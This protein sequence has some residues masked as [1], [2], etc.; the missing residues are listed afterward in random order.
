MVLVLCM[1]FVLSLASGSAVGVDE[2]EAILQKKETK[3]I[4]LLGRDSSSGLADAIII[5][6][7]NADREKLTLLQIPRDTYIF[8]SEEKYKKINGASAILGSDSALCNRLSDSF[9]IELDGYIS[10]DTELVRDAVDM[11]GGVEL[12]VPMDMD[13]DDPYQNLSI[14]LKAGRQRLTGSQAVGFVR[15]RA[16]YL[17]ADLGRIDAQKLFLAALA[18]SAVEKL[19]SR[20]IIPLAKIALR[21]IKTDLP[22]TDIAV[23]SKELLK[24]T[25]EKLEFVTLPGEEV[26]SSTSGAWFYILSRSGCERL[27]EALG[28]ETAFDSEHIFSDSARKE[29]ED[30]YGRDIEARIYNAA[31]LDGEGIEIIPKK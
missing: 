5:A 29:F 18:K 8:T 11:L 13:Y 4:L 17:R 16:G 22:I 27:F 6:S 12:N 3:N 20:D 23:L 2:R 15:Y 7:V 21:Y 26:Q 14:H 31:A 28:A 24:M 25:P 10:F 19:D 1:A 30:I 9:G